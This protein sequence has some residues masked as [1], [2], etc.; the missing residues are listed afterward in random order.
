MGRGGACFLTFINC[1]RE[2]SSFFGWGGRDMMM[3][4]MFAAM[5]MAMDMGMSWIGSMMMA[6][7]FVG[8]ALIKRTRVLFFR[9]STPSF[10]YRCEK[11]TRWREGGRKGGKRGILLTL[12]TVF[13]V[14]FTTMLRVGCVFFYKR[15][16]RRERRKKHTKMRMFFWC[17]RDLTLA[18]GR[19]KDRLIP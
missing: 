2:I 15:V 1:R 17:A 5:A 16:R 3:G 12:R 8:G 10:S 18:M 14:F 7:T 19:K 13:T 6:M 9:P 4:R 11:H